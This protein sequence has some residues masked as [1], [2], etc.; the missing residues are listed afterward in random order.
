[1]KPCLGGE[2]IL[3]PAFLKAKLSQSADTEAAGGVVEG[4]RE[5]PQRLMVRG[6]AECSPAPNAGNDDLYRP[7]GKQ[8]PNRG[9]GV[10]S[11]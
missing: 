3:G 4:H 8:L 9:P 2:R 6:E 1:M 11:S 7:M 10:E 5:M